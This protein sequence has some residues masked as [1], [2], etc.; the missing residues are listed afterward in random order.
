[1]LLAMGSLLSVENPDESTRKLAYLCCEEIAII[2][3]ESTKKKRKGNIPIKQERRLDTYDRLLY[4]SSHRLIMM[5]FDK[6]FGQFIFTKHDRLIF[7]S[8]EEQS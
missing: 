5:P 6:V 2:N 3:K 7:D 8:S 1:M 4:Q